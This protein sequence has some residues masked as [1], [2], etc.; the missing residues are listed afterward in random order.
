MALKTQHTDLST[1]PLDEGDAQAGLPASSLISF[2]WVHS[3]AGA[4]KDK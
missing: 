1:H 2:P 3:T 4:G